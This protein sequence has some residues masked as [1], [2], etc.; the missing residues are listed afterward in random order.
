MAGKLAVRLY[1]MLRLQVNY[2]QL[3]Q[4]SH[5]GQPGTSWSWL[6]PASWLGTLPPQSVGEFE[7]RIMVLTQVEIG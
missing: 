6:I 3:I 1:W 5:A 4:G 7:D 2:A